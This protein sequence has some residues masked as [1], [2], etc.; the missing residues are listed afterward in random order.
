[1]ASNVEKEIGSSVLVNNTSTE[2]VEAE[3][4]LKSLE[5][6]LALLERVTRRL[7]YLG[8][9]IVILTFTCL[10]FSALITNGV[11]YIGNDGFYVPIYFLYIPFFSSLLSIIFYE[12][13]R[14]H[15]DALFEEI[16]DELQWH[17]DGSKTAAISE[18]KPRLQSRII[19]RNY[20]RTTD[21]I[22]IPG[23]YGP[24][25]YALINIAILFITLLLLRSLFLRY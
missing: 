6:N 2:N 12:T 1:M 10:L 18:K 5:Q 11:F 17:I 23:K 15:G 3:T 22:L 4:S 24:A 9:L 7:R 25:M 16:S 14:K 19:L 13:Y 21:L 20:A 8:I